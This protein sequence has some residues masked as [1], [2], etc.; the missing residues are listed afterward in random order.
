LL[1][2]DARINS[3]RATLHFIHPNIE[4]TLS[5]ELLGRE[6]CAR[7][8]D[9]AILQLISLDGTVEA[10]DF[11]TFAN[12]HCRTCSFLDFCAAGQDWLKRN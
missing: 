9:E 4:K 3:L 7:A 5:A 6:T 2:R 8:V 11:P 1:P 10:E 12:A